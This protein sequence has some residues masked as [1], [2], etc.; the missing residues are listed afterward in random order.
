MRKDLVRCPHCEEPPQGEE[1]ALAVFRKVMDDKIHVYCCE[2]LIK[3]DK[4]E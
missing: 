1:C 2:T 4:Q 3:R